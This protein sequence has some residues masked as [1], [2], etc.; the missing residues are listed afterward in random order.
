MRDAVFQPR[1]QSSAWD[2]IQ[3]FIDGLAE[4]AAFISRDG[5]ILAVNRH[6]RVQV[7]KQARSGLQISRDY[8]AYLVGLVARGDKGA[9]PILQ[10]FRDI[11]EGKRDGSAICIGG[12][13][14]SA[15]MTS[16][17]SSPQWRSMVISTFWSPFTM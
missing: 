11:R 8:D 16:R 1:A 13:V 9:T 15:A 6:W 10:A 3:S 7:E 14:L 17:S 4:Q 12:S 2:E 5:T